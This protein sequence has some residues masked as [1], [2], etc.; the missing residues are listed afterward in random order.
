MPFS[1]DNDDILAIQAVID[2]GLCELSG[3]PFRLD[4]GRTADSPSFDRIVPEIGYVRGNVRVVCH[5]LNAGM[6]NWGASELFRIVSIWLSNGNAIVPQVAASF[7]TAALE[8][9]P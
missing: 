7:V 6:G 2:K 8:A 5:C 9:M 1:L 4:G 3:A